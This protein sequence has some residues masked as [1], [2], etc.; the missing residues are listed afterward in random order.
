M[1]NKDV[2]KALEEIQNTLNQNQSQVYDLIAKLKEEEILKQLKNLE[3][4]STAVIQKEFK[5]GYVISSRI[6]E[7]FEEKGLISRKGKSLVFKINK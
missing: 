5:L 6:L 3:T 2:L 1:K 4:I 7:S